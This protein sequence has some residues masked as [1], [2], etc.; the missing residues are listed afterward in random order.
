[1]CVAFPSF[2]GC[3]IKLQVRISAGS[4]RDVFDRTLSQRGPSEVR[5]QND[6]S[7]VDDCPQGISNRGAQFTLNGVRQARHQE[8]DCFCI[9]ITS[10]DFLS[11]PLQ[12]DSCCRR[13]RHSSIALDQG[14]HPA[15]AQELIYGRQLAV[16]I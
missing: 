1:M 14:L 16:K 11:R 8:V 13:D 2:A 5:V 6:P 4:A 9:E 3:E 15:S 10:A 7:R 12:N